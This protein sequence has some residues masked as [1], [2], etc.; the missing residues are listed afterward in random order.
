LS[1]SDSKGAGILGTGFAVPQQVVTNDDLSR[2]VETSDEWIASRTG[3][4]QRYVCS[5]QET[6]ATLSIE[7]ARSAL[8]DSGITPDQLDLILLAT[9]TGDHIWPASACLVQ[10]ALGAVN[11]AAMD[12]SA[13]CSGFVYAL[14]LASSLIRSG[15][16]RYVLVIGTDTLT[17][18]LNWQDRKT[19]VLF[20]DGSGAVVVGPC[21]PQEGVLSSVMGSDGC[22][23]EQIW[24]EAGGTALPLTP[25]L[26]AAGRG[27][28]TMQGP[29]VYKFAVKIMGETSLEAL[30]RAGLTPDQVDLFIPHQANTRIIRAA[31]E[32]MGLPDE[33]VFINVDRFGNTSAGSIPIALTEARRQG[34]VKR[35]SILVFVGFG[36]GLTWGANV[37]RWNLNEPAGS[38]TQ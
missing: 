18:H 4:R 33:K 34:L 26:A 27:C 22:G 5:P 30:R 25:E 23:F 9:A 37:L 7:S 20:G 24:L 21:S 31:Q 19:C 3:I 16:M 35:G 38:P 14:T 15:T 12:I 13:A 36:A 6:T 10:R 28:L 29:E 11:A 1:V 32:R 2:I 17:K 8:A